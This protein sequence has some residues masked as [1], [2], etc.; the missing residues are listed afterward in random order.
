[1]SVKELRRLME[2]GEAS[3]ITL[4]MPLHATSQVETVADDFDPGTNYSGNDGSV[5]W[6]GNWQEFGES[7]G[8]NRG[9]VRTRYS[10]RC[11]AGECLRIGGDE[12]SINR[13]GLR[14]QLDTSAAHSI[15]LTFSYRRSVDESG[16]SV[17]LEVSDDGGSQWSTLATYSLNSNDSR[18]VSQSFDLSG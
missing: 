1:M 8:A 16:G 7:N 10:S 5:D 2:Q 18:Q 4:D 14:R 13:K 3:Y 12:T 9:R 11:A 15:T 17:A 6:S